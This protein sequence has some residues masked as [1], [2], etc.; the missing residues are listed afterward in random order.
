MKYLAV[1]L[2]IVAALILAA[3]VYYASGWLL[4]WLSNAFGYQS[5]IG[6]MFGV[7]MVIVSP[8]GYG[9]FLYPLLV[10]IF[11]LLIGKSVLAIKSSISRRR[12]T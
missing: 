1:A 11:Y 6:H 2:K 3:I 7:A 8:L 9:I 4:G 12:K 5:E 10:V